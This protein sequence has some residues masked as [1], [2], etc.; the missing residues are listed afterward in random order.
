LLIKI[1]AEDATF[2]VP[3]VWWPNLPVC[4]VPLIRWTS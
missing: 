1:C 2:G 4:P 3:L